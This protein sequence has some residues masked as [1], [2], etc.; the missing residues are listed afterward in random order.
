MGSL[1]LALPVFMFQVR[2]ARCGLSWAN[3]CCSII[4]RESRLLSVLYPPLWSSVQARVSPVSGGT[5][6][7]YKA[8]L[9]S[10]TTTSIAT[11][12]VVSVSSVATAPCLTF[13]RED[14]LF[15]TLYWRVDADSLH[16]TNH[17]YY[18]LPFLYLA[19]VVLAAM[20]V[21]LSDALSLSFGI[22]QSW[23][24]G[25]M[26]RF[27]MVDHFL[28]GTLGDEE[29]A[30]RMESFLPN[31]N[32]LVTSK[33]K[34]VEV[35]QPA[36]RNELVLALKQTTWIPFVTGEG[37]LRPN[38]DDNSYTTGDCPA[39]EEDMDYDEFYLDGGFSRVLHPAC[40]FDLWVPNTWIN[41]LY[42]LNPAMTSSQ[43]ETMWTEGRNFDHPLL[44]SQ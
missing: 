24:A 12:R 22:Q 21:S 26:T 2:H 19:G 34:G 17:L 27:E 44:A 28:E 33:G 23:L 9:D 15:S 16:T 37:V 40:E 39:N 4:S 36:S 8:S 41:M 18:P 42:T 43:V 25:N 11:L 20:N 10:M 6:V 5:W 13:E 29:Y 38:D 7:R 14:I 31:L 1:L 30:E 3:G 35:V 32:V